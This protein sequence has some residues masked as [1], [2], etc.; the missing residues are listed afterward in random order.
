MIL[1]QMLQLHR[2]VITD[3]V[4]YIMAVWLPA[5]A[6]D[7]QI[8]SFMQADHITKLSMRICICISLKHRIF[9]W[10]R[11]ILCDTCAVCEPKPEICHVMFVVIIVCH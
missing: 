4:R 2:M 6:C 11:S 3:C 5:S 10:L 9:L 7:N 1:D 8:I